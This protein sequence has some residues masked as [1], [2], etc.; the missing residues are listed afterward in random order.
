[1]S[2]FPKVAYIEFK[3][4]RGLT[5][6]REATPEEM[7]PRRELF[8]KIQLARQCVVEAEEMLKKLQDRCDHKL[9][10]DRE[11]FPY[12]VRTCVTCG[13]SLGLI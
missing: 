3:N 11:G 7:A 6:N 1:M 4:S 12:D 13:K 10:T 5:E 2:A 8:E 9:F